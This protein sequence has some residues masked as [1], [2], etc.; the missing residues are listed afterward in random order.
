[1]NNKLSKLLKTFALLKVL[2]KAKNTPIDMTAEEA[3]N[4]HENLVNVLESPSHKDDI[5]E[6]KKQKKELKEYKE[7]LEKTKSPSKHIPLHRL[8]QIQRDNHI[9]EGGNEYDAGEVK[10]AINE[11]SHAIAQRQVKDADRRDRLGPD[12]DKQDHSDLLSYLSNNP[13]KKSNV[14]IDLEK[15]LTEDYDLSDLIKADNR[16]THPGQQHPLDPNQHAGVMSNGIVGWKYTPQATRRYLSDIWEG[17]NDILSKYP[18]HKEAVSKL[19]DSVLSHP[20]THFIPTQ[21]NV[22]SP[23]H[24]MRARHLRQLTMYPDSAN[25]IPKDDGNIVFATHRH[26]KQK[27]E[28]TSYWTFNKDKGVIGYEEKDG[29]Q[30]LNAKVPTVQSSPDIKTE[31]ATVRRVSPGV[32]VRQKDRVSKSENYTEADD[33]MDNNKSRRII[34]NKGEMVRDDVPDEESRNNLLL[35]NLYKS[36]MK[37]FLDNSDFFNTWKKSYKLYKADEQSNTLYHYGRTPGLKQIDPKFMGT[38]TKGDFNRK[39]DPSKIPDYPHSIFAYK[40]DEPE[41]IVKQGAVSKYKLD[42]TPDQELY[43]ISKDP[44]NLVSGAVKENNG[45]WNIENVFNKIKGAGYYGAHVSDKDAH[46]VIR[47]TVH[48]FYPH[49]VSSEEGLR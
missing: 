26:S 45:I 46:P 9:G 44:E 24:D 42:L 1:M 43:D 47:N 31:Q 14:D 12:H 29:H 5:V 30:I 23:I 34:P 41:D 17:K 15:S 40:V 33:S 4:E 8:K 16:P 18:N 39:F 25:I 20:D 37:R 21:S 6:A 7:Q 35:Q 19:Y 2:S 28:F 22:R 13:I 10:D 38:G 49:N 27:P 36:E 11:R 3:V 32:V 48:L